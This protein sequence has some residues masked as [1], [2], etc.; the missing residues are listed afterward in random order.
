[1][2]YVVTHLKFWI[3]LSCFSTTL[4]AQNNLKVG[5][6]RRSTY[7]TTGTIEEAS[8]SIR[9]KGLYLEY[10]LYL[11][12]SGKGSGFNP[13]D[14]LEVTLNFTLPE[15]AIVTDSWL[16]IYNDICRARILDV[17]SAREIYE[18]I[19][20][21]RTDP[22]LL[23]KSSPTQYQLRVF[24]LPASETRKV[25]ITYLL[26]LSWSPTQVSA[27]LPT[28]IVN[29]SRYPVK[30]FP[31][32]IWSDKD[33]NN[34]QL[35]N[36]N[37][38]GFQDGMDPVWGPYKSTTLYTYTSYPA[39]NV[40]FES[41]IKNGI[42]FNY[43]DDGKETYYQMA[44]RPAVFIPKSK[45]KKTA[46]LLD[47]NEASASMT[48]ET[49]VN[50]FKLEILNTLNEND[51][52][53]IL[54][55]N[56]NIQK[57]SDI[58]LPATKENIEDALKDLTK[59]SSFSTMPI[60]II[61]GLNFINTNSGNGR[62]LLISNSNNYGSH[63]V[64]NEIL[65]NINKVNHSRIPIDILDYCDKYIVYTI[66]GRN[67]YNNQY[68]YINLSNFTGGNYVTIKNSF[69]NSLSEI[70][71]FDYQR[72]KGLDFHLKIDQ[73]ISYGKYQ[74]TEYDIYFDLNKTFLQTGLIKG[75]FPITIELSGE[76]NN[77]LFYK[78][79]SI[80][81]QLAIPSDSANKT[82]WSAIGLFKQESK[83]K[84]TDNP[85]VIEII[86]SSISNRILTKYT[87][88]LCVEDTTLY[89][90]TCFDETGIPT[91]TDDETQDSLY[92]VKAFPNPFSEQI[93]I[94]L[95]LD[96]STT[97][98][99]WQGE[100]F[101]LS[102]RVIHRFMIRNSSGAKIIQYNWNGQSDSGH[103]ISKGSYIL[104]L[105]NQNRSVYQK[106]IKM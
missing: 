88:F 17:W 77:E 33:F 58:W 46:Y 31:I 64:S 90:R 99:D 44:I 72:V 103:S 87:A 49:F 40:M 36:F 24:P 43:F 15:N 66:N 5:D 104:K 8:L 37:P 26:P 82:I 67:Y 81:Q 101:D 11:T 53:N 2:K 48:K 16:W 6:P 23:T 19:V 1:M 45:S 38:F 57:H 76:L 35:D 34:P 25:K 89:C 96:P 80:D 65:T 75:S 92:I 56:F 84:S 28:N 61:E 97:N 12:F 54:F 3:L 50:L 105:R 9:N 100:F 91:D 30:A 59:L 83:I 29:T 52:F 32:L 47:Y 79:I 7:T 39:I 95:H 70:L 22:S 13:K 63:V 78:N 69:S 20:K 18:N 42:Y 14:S 62:L 21:R 85:G 98:G 55:S 68:F 102:G 4:I 94:E 74:L 71:L 41:P 93:T 73:G 86:K 51:S 106:I 27:P 60:L 10:G